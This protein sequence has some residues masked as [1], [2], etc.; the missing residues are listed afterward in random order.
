[1]LSR[2]SHIRLCATLWTV[3]CQAPLSLYG[4]LQARIL[5]WAAMPSS[6]GS[7]RP[8][9][10]TWIS[11]ISC[12]GKRVLY[13]YCHLGSPPSQLISAN[14]SRG[15]ERGAFLADSTNHWFESVDLAL[16]TA[17]NQSHDQGDRLTRLAWPWLSKPQSCAHPWGVASMISTHT[18]YAE[19]EERWFPKGKPRRCN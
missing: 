8:R 1:M 18:V 7:S 12:F 14:N 2:F 10:R 13:H 5:E 11:Y 9:D 19:S 16:D 6:R 15:R 3:V 4:I 17:L